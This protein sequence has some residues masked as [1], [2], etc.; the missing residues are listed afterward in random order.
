[1]PRA[2]L[3]L[4]LLAAALAAIDCGSKR[5][6]GPRTLTLWAHAGQAAERAALEATVARFN[7]AQDT[8][9]LELTLLPE[10]GYNAQVQAAALA[11]DLPDLLEFDGPFLQAYAA[12]GH[13][14]PLAAL[15]PDSL[16]RDLLPSLI[17]QGSY[18]DSLYAVGQFDSGL[19]LY[20]RRSLLLAAGARLPQS[21][22]NAW[23]AAEF[24][25][26]LEALAA[27]DADGAVLDLH[28]DYRGEWL[29]YAFLPWLWSAGGGLIGGGPPAR[30]TGT[31]DSP[32]SLRVMQALQGWLAAGRIDANIDGAAFTAGRAALSLGGHWNYP[33]YREAWGEDLLLLPLPDWGEGSVSAQGSWQWGV[34]RRADAGAAAACLRALLAPAAVLEVCAANSAVPGRRSVLAESPLYAPG[35]PL[36]LFAEQLL[37]GGTRPRPRSAA[38]PLLT[39][40]FQ[41]LVEDLRAGAEPAALLAKSAAAIDAELAA[42]ETEP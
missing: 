17:A 23:S 26:L 40:R 4:L 11:G 25:A 20:G 16:R 30:A 8:L 5:A 28:L 1:M 42:L 13:L 9:R 29:S 35:G 2:W 33:A 34:T 31:L 3:P 32:A 24:A 12:G 36:R 14:R 6:G 27:R 22:A 19:G 15:L 10:G 39:S 7:A 21:A 37:G 18:G 41:A 38:Y